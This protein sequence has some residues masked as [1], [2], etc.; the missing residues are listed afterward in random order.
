MQKFQVWK[1][2]AE[3]KKRTEK[4]P[5]LFPMENPVKLQNWKSSSLQTTLVHKY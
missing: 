3:N 5:V 1:S 2:L 4:D